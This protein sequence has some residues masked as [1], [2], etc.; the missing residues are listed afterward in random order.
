MDVDEEPKEVFSNL[1]TLSENLELDLQEDN[2]TEL[3]GVNMS[4]LV[5]RNISNF[6]QE[7]S[8][9]LQAANLLSLQLF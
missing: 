8:N 6:L 7:I 3:F 1:V 9:I 5:I 4:N 2:F